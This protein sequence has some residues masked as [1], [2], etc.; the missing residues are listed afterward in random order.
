MACQILPQKIWFFHHRH[1]YWHYAEQLTKL[2]A[3]IH[4]FWGSQESID[5]FDTM[6]IQALH[7]LVED[8]L[9]YVL[10]R[11]WSISQVHVCR[12]EQPSN[13]DE[14]GIE[15]R[16]EVSWP[17]FHLD[18]LYLKFCPFVSDFDTSLLRLSQTCRA[19]FRFWS[20]SKIGTSTFT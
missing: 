3:Q 10:S 19:S 20:G 14:V 5:Y 8:C 13:V 12:L 7:P 11:N 18:W 6:C 16:L 15:P 2:Q 1:F 17:A 4:R 9:L